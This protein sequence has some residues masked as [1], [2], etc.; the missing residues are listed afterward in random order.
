MP[1]LHRVAGL[2]AGH[3]RCR[4][5]LFIQSR[6]VDFFVIRGVA[7]TLALE[8]AGT[9]VFVC[10]AIL[11]ANQRRAVYQRKETYILMSLDELLD[12]ARGELVQLLVRAKD[13]DGDVD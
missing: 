5:H 1:D 9:F 12:V 6:L 2:W 7:V 13:D 3:V 8:V 11:T 10:A 4:V